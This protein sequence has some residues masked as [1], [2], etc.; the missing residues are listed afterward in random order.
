MNEAGCTWELG[1]RGRNWARSVWEVEMNRGATGEKGMGILGRTG[2]GGE[3]VRCEGLLTTRNIFSQK[4]YVIQVCL[5]LFNHCLSHVNGLSSIT[6][7][8]TSHCTS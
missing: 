7:H 4:N 3:R 5:A 8:G 2:W 1:R 6:D